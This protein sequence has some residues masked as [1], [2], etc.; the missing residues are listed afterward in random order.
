MLDNA[1]A[2]ECSYRID[3]LM[4]FRWFCPLNSFAMFKYLK[5]LMILVSFRIIVL[6]GVGD[7]IKYYTLLK[8]NEYIH[9]L[10]TKKKILILKTISKN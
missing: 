2:M 6:L 10:L 7:R 8:P 3:Q 5:L 1:V 9:H 4:Q